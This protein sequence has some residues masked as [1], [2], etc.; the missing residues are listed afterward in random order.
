MNW[1]E[2][3]ILLT[4][5]AGFLGS[6]VLEELLSRGASRERIEIPRLSSC[7]LRRKENCGKVVKDKDIVIHLAANVGGIGYN[8][9]HPG[10]LFYDNIMMSTHLMEEARKEG[11]EKYTALGTVCAYPKNT[12]VPFKEENLWDG[13]PEETN[14]PYGLAKKMQLVQ[15]KA[16]RKQYDFNSIFLIPVNL[17]G[18]RDNFDPE[19]SHVIPAIIKKG[20]EARKNDRDEITAWGT[21]EPTREFLYVEDAAKGIVDATEKYDKSE[22]VNLGSGEEISIRE[23]VNLICNLMDFDGNIRWETS[24]PDGQP[25]R[26]L[27]VSKAKKEFGFETKTKLEEGI[28]ETI[29]WYVEKRRNE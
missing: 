29:D 26:K 3:E 19:K 4:G 21:G 1:S 23:L 20:Y 27:D 7:D 14:A 28:K 6:F 10:D 5:G 17:Y 15:S 18:P 24:K 8:K 22:P 25:R 9:R 11:V 13:Y 2:K 12:P 16:Y